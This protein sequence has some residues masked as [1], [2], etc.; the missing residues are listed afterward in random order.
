MTV[1]ALGGDPPKKAGAIPVF[2]TEQAAKDFLKK[3]RVSAPIHDIPTHRDLVKIL[4]QAR[5]ELVTLVV[6]NPEDANRPAEGMPLDKYLSLAKKA[7]PKAKARG[8]R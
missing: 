3:S 1:D 8:S 7:K 5:R 2:Y 6:I 4:E